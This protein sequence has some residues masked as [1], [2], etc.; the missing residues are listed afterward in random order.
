MDYAAA[1]AGIDDQDSL[2]GL[3]LKIK[4]RRNACRVGPIIDDSNLIG[5]D[6]FTDSMVEP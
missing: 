1:D 4:G 2:P 6:L 3:P 5:K